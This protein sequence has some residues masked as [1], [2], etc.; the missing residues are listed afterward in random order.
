M[1][2]EQIPVEQYPHAG[3]NRQE[4]TVRRIYSIADFGAAGDGVTM[5]TGAIQQAI[6]TAYADGGGDVVMPAGTYLSGDILLKSRVTLRLLSGAT[7]QGSRDPMD[8]HHYRALCAIPPEDISDEPWKRTA[9]DLSV[10]PNI[11]KAGSRWNNALIRAYRAHDIAVIGEEGAVIDGSNTYDELGEENY[12]GPHG[13]TFF[14]CSN[15]LLEGYTIRNT[16]NWAHNLAFAENVLM[17]GVTVLAGHDGV[18][19]RGSTNVTIRSCEFYTGDDSVAGFANTNV[20]V[21]DCVLNSACSAFRSG[22]TNMLVRKCRMYGPGRYCFRGSLTKEEKAA[23]VPSATAGHRTNMLSA[24]TYFADFSYPIREQPG[25]ILI[26][27]CAI[28]MADRFLHYNFSGN[29]TWQKNRPLESITFRN[30]TATGISMPINAY[31]SEDVPLK[32]AIENTTIG[33]RKGADLRALIHA[34]HFDT[35]RLCG[36][37]ISGF[38]GDCLVRTWTDGNVIT[39]DTDAGGALIKKPA[40]E[41]FFARPI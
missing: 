24:F 23:S 37:R 35:I 10:K 21:E 33:I 25:S 41:A 36:V 40:G 18:H 14:E 5:D 28:D 27:D 22:A 3:T 38:R 34:A 13:M 39:K 9:Y 26:E 20:L 19:F 29:E 8:Y 17:K 12:R 6:D 4:K 1:N 15:I 7:L 31:G 11:R 2:Q 30:I 16:G 32:L